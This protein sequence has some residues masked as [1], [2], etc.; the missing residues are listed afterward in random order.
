M[1][2]IWKDIE[3]YEGLYQVSTLSRVK[4]LERKSEVDNGETVYLKSVRERILR[5]GLNEHGYLKVDLC[6]N[7]IIW[8]IVT[9]RL[10]AIAFIPN[11]ENK[12]QVNHKNGIRTDNRIE[13]LEWVTA[14]ENQLHAYRE[15]KRIKPIGNSG[16]F[17]D[18]H[19]LSKSVLKLDLSG[20]V[21]CEYGSIRE[22]ERD[23][24]VNNTNIVNVC[25]GKSIT[26]G[27]YKWKYKS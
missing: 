20:N 3:D 7:A 12:S 22:A 18:K 13:N 23:T 11:P 27:G 26:A 9:H 17:G 6:K 1:E 24:K 8:S 19:H 15:L 25:K 10:A 14:S 4:S 2:E 21:I 16:R 5:Q